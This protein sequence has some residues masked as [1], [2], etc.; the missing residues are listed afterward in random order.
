MDVMFPLMDKASML[1]L[2][3]MKQVSSLCGII[4]KSFCCGYFGDH[5]FFCL[6]NAWGEHSYIVEDM[7]VWQGLSNPYPLQTK[8]SAIFWT[9]CRQIT[10]NIWKYSP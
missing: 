5:R 7:D 1:L 3:T 8:I 9:L 6:R 10:E 2:L 4:P